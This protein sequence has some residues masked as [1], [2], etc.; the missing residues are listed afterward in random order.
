MGIE[1][2]EK[3]KRV[4]RG[5]LTPLTSDYA[6]DTLTFILNPWFA[7]AWKAL[8]II[9]REHGKSESFWVAGLWTSQ[10]IYGLSSGQVSRRDLTPTTSEYALG[11]LMIVWNL[12]LDRPE[13]LRTYRMEHQQLE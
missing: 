3:P 5:D 6:L 10:N 1:A 12:S 7:W 9:R 8:G 2:R 4:S 11:T 13:S